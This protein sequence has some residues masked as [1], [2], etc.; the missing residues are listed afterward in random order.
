MVLS[1]IICV[2]ESFSLGAQ[3]MEGISITKDIIYGKV[4]GV[5]L[6]LD[7]AMPAEGK[8]YLSCID[9]FSWR[10]MATG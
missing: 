9:F 7:M 1:I 5:D 3:S 6:K 2:L 8:A 10:R 4:Q